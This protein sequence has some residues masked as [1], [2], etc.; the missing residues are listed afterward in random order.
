MN[1]KKITELSKRLSWLLRHGAVESGLTMDAAGWCAEQDVLRRMHISQDT[2]RQVV[3]ENTKARLQWEQGRIRACQGHS[4][5]GTPVT[6][7]AL[8]A[9]WNLYDGAGPLWHGT[10]L[11]ALP[12]IAREG[13]KPMER[14]HVH[15]A[16]AMDSKV[17]KRAGVA[18]L[19]GISVEILAR[20]GLR[21]FES[22]NGVLLTRHVPAE[23]IVDVV[24]CTRAAQARQEELRAMF[25]RTPVGQ[26]GP[27]G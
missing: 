20:C 19:I 9:S 21:V 27:I 15:L 25:S 10:G 24:A 17:G 18:V 12:S 14:T 23:A 3:E 13:L 16:S 1:E 8:E 26:S 5:A 2:L 4:T 11:D 22:P 7:E 6:A